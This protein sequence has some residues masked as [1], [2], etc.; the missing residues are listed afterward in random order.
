MKIKKIFYFYCLLS[1]LF[2]TAIS[3]T[4]PANYLPVKPS[5][6]AE[7]KRIIDD[8][9]LL[10]YSDRKNIESQ[11]R[12]FE[13]STSNQIIV[14]TIKTL[15]GYEAAEFAT[16]IGDQWKA[17]SEKQ[18]NG[19]VLLICDGTGENGITEKK[20]VFIAVGKGL[21][22]ALPDGAVGS[23]IRNEIIPNL[24]GGQYYSAI[25]SG[26]TAIQQAAVGE[27]KIKNTANSNSSALDTIP[28]WVIILFFLFVVL[29]ILR[30]N[31]T[32]NKGG[33]ASRRGFKDYNAPT[34]FPFI[35]G[36]N[37]GGGM[38]D[39]NSGGGGID[40]GNFG[41]GDFGGGGAGGDW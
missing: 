25:N 17:G 14:V 35:G 27:Y 10:S 21:E 31:K 39:N 7:F 26:I 41:G 4:I 15:H 36:G 33:M 38:F 23:I 8:A 13:D 29:F 1:I 11:L 20:K 32:M 12:Y 18:D 34:F 2:N 3:Q 37:S 6:N 9:N 22:G 40:V 19:V 16:E 5:T 30:A 28:S 24:K